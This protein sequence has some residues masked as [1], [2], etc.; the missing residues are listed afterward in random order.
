MTPA[1][2]VANTFRE[3]SGRVLAA[4]ISQF[5]D[6]DLAE[7]ALQEALLLALEKWPKQGT[8]RNPGAW[9]TTIAK[10]RLIDRLRR[11]QTADRKQVELIEAWQNTSGSPKRVRDG[12]LPG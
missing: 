6:F 7:D 12:N 8:P 1:E 9:M 3:E 4:L 10:R 2:I 5:G 11:H